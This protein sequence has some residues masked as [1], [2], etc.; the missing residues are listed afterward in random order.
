LACK[1]LICNILYVSGFKFQVSINLRFI[2]LILIKFQK[3]K[4][5]IWNSEEFYP[6]LPSKEISNNF[7]ASIANS[8]GNLFKTS[9]LN[10]LTIRAMARSVSIPLWLQ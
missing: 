10:P 1:F 5:E 4:L 6:T 7:W 8:I 3:L 9:L 2:Y